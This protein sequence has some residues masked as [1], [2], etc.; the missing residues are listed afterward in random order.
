[1]VRQR[2]ERAL[3]DMGE[4]AIPALTG[5]AAEALPE[6][7]ERLQRIIDEIRQSTTSSRRGM[8]P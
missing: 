1:M 8:M 7:R 5:A 6:T 3:V 2:A 4:A